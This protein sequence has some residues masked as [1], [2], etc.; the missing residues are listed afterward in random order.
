MRHMVLYDSKG[1]DASAFGQMYGSFYDYTVDRCRVDRSQGIWGQ[2]GWFVTIRDNLLNGASSYHPGIGM[3][4]PN[5]EHNA[6]FGYTGLDNHRIRVTKSG[7]LQYPDRKMPLFVDEVVGRPIPTT[8]GLVLRGNVLRY[9][10]RLVAQPWTGDSAPGPRPGG[11]IFRDVVVDGNSI[12][13]SAVGVQLGPNVGGAVLSRNAFRNVDRPLLRGKTTDVI[14]LGP[15]DEGEPLF[16]AAGLSGWVEEQH[17]KF[18]ARNPGVISTWKLRDGVLSCDGSHGNCGFLR[19][20]R[21]VS[22]FTLRLRYR[23]SSGCNSGVCFRIPAPYRGREGDPQPSETGFEVQIRDDQ[24]EGPSLTSTGAIYNVRAPEV[25][26]ARAAGEWNDLQIEAQGSRIRATLNG[27]TVQD[28]DQETEAM[29]R[30]RPR[31]GHLVFQNHGFDI[32]FR[33]VRL[34]DRTPPSA[35]R[36]RP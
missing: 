3:R 9:G 24:G 23:M 4:G 2:M 18:R 28:L 16:A 36:P 17:D 15:A 10:H 13:D 7:A 1:T 29:L 22:D 21:V 30:K 5:P 31:S 19:S 14:D 8:L 12:E 27:R 32:E 20:E 11:V 25:N 35:R 34:I 26:V 33:D 6:P